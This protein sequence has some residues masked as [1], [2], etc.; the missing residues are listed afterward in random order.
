MMGPWLVSIALCVHLAVPH[1]DK[2]ADGEDPTSAGPCHPNPCHNG[3]TCEI[4]ETFRGDT[5][6]G[7]VCKCPSGFNG[8]HCQ[9][10][11]NE[12]ERSP[13]RNGGICTDLVANYSCECP[14]E[15]MGRN[16]QYKC[17]GPLGMEGGIISNQQI[18]ASSTHR[19]LFGL[20]KWYPYF[21]RLNKKGLVNAWTA[22]END[23]WP[24][25]QVTDY[26][27]API[28]A[29]YVRIYPQVCRRHCTLRMELLGCELTGCSEPMGMKSGHIQDYQIT[30]S[31]IFR[32]LNMD[33]FTWEPGKARL[34]KQGKVNAWTSG[35]SDQSQWLQVDMLRPTKITGVITQG[36]KDF[37]HVQFV[38]SYK[39]AYSNTGERWLIYQDVKQKKDKV[40]QGNF[41]NDT[42]R[43]NVIDPP[44]YA[45]FIRILPWSWYGRITLR[46]EL[47]GCTEEE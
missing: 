41:D 39:L 2:A 43:K 21:A 10:N 18:T 42:H 27:T 38:G 9:H 24:W 13:C 16:C 33:M 26:I 15:Y 14:G 28:E 30:A 19:A 44:I 20:Q 29:Q 6:I 47:L 12:C 11:V 17:S 3:G 4:S 8:I 7:Y 46:A 23:R 37:G 32:T 35:H 1:L 45:R 40:F 31:S 25:I 36:A 5:F 22:A 34:D